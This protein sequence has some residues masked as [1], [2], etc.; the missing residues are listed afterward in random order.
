MQKAKKTAD[1]KMVVNCEMKSLQFFILRRLESRQNYFK[2]SNFFCGESFSQ[3]VS[4]SVVFKAIE[5]LA[6][7]LQRLAWLAQRSTRE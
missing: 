1:A 5:T 2:C 4:Q 6:K 7:E 3:S